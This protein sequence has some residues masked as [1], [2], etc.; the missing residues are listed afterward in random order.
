MTVPEYVAR[1]TERM[2][3]S[4]A[5]FLA[6][7]S[8]DKLKWCP[9][10]DGSAGSRSVLEQVSECIAVNHMMAK[11][12]R[13]EAVN[14]APGAYPTIAFADCN[15]AQQRLLASAKDLADA[16]RGMTDED[17]QREY[18]HP[19]ALMRGENM[20]IMA[21]RNMAYHAGQINYIQMLYGDAEFHVPPTWR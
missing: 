10:L 4:L 17:L 12:L 15:D 21:L 5:H 20:I 1:Q 2:A 11:L 16:L 18:Q 13:G 14:A 6:T 9:E 7:T 19:R 8:E 3:E